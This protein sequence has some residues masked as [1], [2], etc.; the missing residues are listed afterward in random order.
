METSSE[1]PKRRKPTTTVP[2]SGPTE[3]L[4][5]RRLLSVLGQ[6]V[7]STCGLKH[8]NH[9]RIRR[10][11]PREFVSVPCCATQ[12]VCVVRCSRRPRSLSRLFSVGFAAGLQWS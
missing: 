1:K 9:C 12:P 7:F 10:T 2:L 3:A 11:M 6:F 4:V 5:C 8:E